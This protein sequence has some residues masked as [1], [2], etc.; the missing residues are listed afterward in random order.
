MIDIRLLGAID[1]KDLLSQPLKDWIDYTI[2]VLEWRLY[3]LN[4]YSKETGQLQRLCCIQD[5]KGVG[6]H[7]VSPYVLYNNILHNLRFD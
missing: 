6:M 4:K 5:L 1:V 3:T 7:M 2:Y